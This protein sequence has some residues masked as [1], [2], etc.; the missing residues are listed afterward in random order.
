M[1][2]A[3]NTSMST[4]RWERRR[5]VLRGSTK[6]LKPVRFWRG[7]APWILSKKYTSHVRSGN[8]EGSSLCAVGSLSA[9]AF[10][11]PSCFW[12]EHKSPACRTKALEVLPA[13]QCFGS[14]LKPNFRSVPCGGSR[15]D[16]T[17]CFMGVLI[18]SL[19]LPGHKSYLVCC[20]PWETKTRGLL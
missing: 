2:Q 6:H 18:I 9:T 1:P 10:G 20:C 3:T 12:E 5:E 4:C 16:R 17:F 19:Y 13:F 14:S 8:R 7:G 15:W 11:A